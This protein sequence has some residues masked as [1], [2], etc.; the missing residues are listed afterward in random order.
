MSRVPGFT[1]PHPHD[2]VTMAGSL[3]GWNVHGLHAYAY[4]HSCMHA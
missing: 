1:A 2:M 4:I 3:C